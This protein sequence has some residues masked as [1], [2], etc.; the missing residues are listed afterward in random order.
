MIQLPPNFA[1]DLLK[2]VGYLLIKF[3]YV[4]AIILGIRLFQWWFDKWVNKKKK[5]LKKR[6]L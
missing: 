2:M 4:W 3:W 5:E 6:S 1:W